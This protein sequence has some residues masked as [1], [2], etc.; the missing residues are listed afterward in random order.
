MLWIQ[1]GDQVNFEDS[2]VWFAFSGREKELCCRFKHGDWSSGFTKTVTTIDSKEGN[3]FIHPLSR[4]H[5]SQFIG[6]GVEG[7]F[8]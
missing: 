7:R 4:G 3:G 5:H 8:Y 1:P 6:L 2:L